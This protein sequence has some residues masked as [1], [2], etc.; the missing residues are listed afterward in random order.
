M[1]KILV[2]GAYPLSE[3]VKKEIERMR[4]SVGN[5]NVQE[6]DSKHL[7]KNPYYINNEDILICGVVL[8]ERLKKLKVRGHIVPLRVQTQ[9][10]LQALARAATYGDQICIIN[11]YKEFINDEVIK[12][13]ELQNLFGITIKQYT[14]RSTEHADEVVK[15]LSS[16]TKNIIVGSGL[17]VELAERYGLLGVLWYGEETIQLSVSIAFDILRAKMLERSNQQRQSIVMENFQDGVIS[18]NRMNRIMH[19]NHEKV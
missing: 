6:V 14:Y 18:L 9:D 12:P 8:A 1:L 4:Q 5:L 10:F 16:D 17:S 11:Y 15:Q 13:S 2:S 19:L 3:Y 7:L